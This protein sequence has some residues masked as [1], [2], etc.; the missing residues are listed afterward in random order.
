MSAGDIEDRISQLEQ[1]VRQL[2]SVVWPEGKA[3]LWWNRVAGAFRQDPVYAEAM[4]LAHEERQSQG[5]EDS[6]V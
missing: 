4:K 3:T 5:S 1:K 6:A 2:E